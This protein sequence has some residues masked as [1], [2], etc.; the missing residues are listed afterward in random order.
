MRD[1]PDLPRAAVERTRRLM[2]ENIND[3]SVSGYEH[4][5]DTI[6]LPDAGDRHVLAAA[7]HCGASVIV[8]ANPRDFPAGPL[9]CHGIE[10]QHPDAF[11]LDL[12]KAAPDEVVAALRDLRDDLK[13]P[14]LAAGALLAAMSRNGL[15]AS[16]EALIAFEG[17]L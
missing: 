16:A 4:L 9:S 13:N 14:P 12:F 10:A 15:S 8:T 11:I 5:I 1:R 6:T 17:E 2:D 7:I 3:A